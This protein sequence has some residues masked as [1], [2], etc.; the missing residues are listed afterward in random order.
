MNT[1]SSELYGLCDVLIFQKTYLDAKNNNSGMMQILFYH[2]PLHFVASY[3]LH[4]KI[5]Y[6]SFEMTK[7]TKIIKLCITPSNKLL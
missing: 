7:I 5:S 6:F 2:G 1:S 4:V 3:L